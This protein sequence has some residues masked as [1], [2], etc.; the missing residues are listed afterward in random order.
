M[1]FLS[2]LEALKFLY[3]KES[4][5]RAPSPSKPAAVETR[6]LPGALTPTPGAPRRWARWGRACARK[7]PA[8]LGARH[9]D[10]SCRGAEM[11]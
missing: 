3:V 11:S 7:R 4:F 6:V 1:L 2:H 9:S 8:L 10:W 5:Q